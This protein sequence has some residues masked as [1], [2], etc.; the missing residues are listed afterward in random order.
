MQFVILILYVFQLLITNKK[1]ANSIN[2]KFGT[3]QIFKK[4][5]Y[6]NSDVFQVNCLNLN[7]YIE[8]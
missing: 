5:K 6:N 4:S 3:R 2:H 7:L 1:L 8:V